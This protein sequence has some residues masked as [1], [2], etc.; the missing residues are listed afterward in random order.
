MPIQRDNIL[1]GKDFDDERYWRV[2]RDSCLLPD[3]ET[4]PNADL[5]EASYLY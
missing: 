5:T 1:F 4:L 2:I 3:L